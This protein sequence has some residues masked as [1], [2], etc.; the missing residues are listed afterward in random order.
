MTK[1]EE[2]LARDRFLSFSISKV[3]FLFSLV[4]EWNSQ[5]TDCDIDYR[6]L[7]LPTFT[8]V[9]TESLP[10]TDYSALLACVKDLYSLQPS[11]QHMYNG[12]EVFPTH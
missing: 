10:L 6:G 4:R 12:I 2:R 8:L 9:P 11:G 1:K 7:S 5:H 3:L